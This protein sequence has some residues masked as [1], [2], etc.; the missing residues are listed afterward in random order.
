M[1]A[2]KSAPTSASTNAPTS[3]PTSAPT[4]APTL[5]LTNAPI[6]APTSAP[7]NAP[8]TTEAFCNA[9]PTGVTTCNNVNCVFDPVNIC[10]DASNVN[11]S[12][13]RN[14][15]TNCETKPGCQFNNPPGSGCTDAAP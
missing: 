9:Q 2:S 11:C 13:L 5:A 12:D 14:G 10:W 6:L 3:A 4:T 1:T 8:T 7:T 15:Q